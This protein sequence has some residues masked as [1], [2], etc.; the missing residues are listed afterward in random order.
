MN[1]CISGMLDVGMLRVEHCYLKVGYLSSDGF[2]VSYLETL[3]GFCALFQ[4]G[5]VLLH[6][7]C[8]SV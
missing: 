7:C 8:M 4:S 3:A 5:G 1:I 6:F 2:P